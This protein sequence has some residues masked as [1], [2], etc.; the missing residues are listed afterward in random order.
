[1]IPDDASACL[2]HIAVADDS[3]CLVSVVLKATACVAA[4]CDL[5]STASV[6]CALGCCWSLVSQVGEIDSFRH[7]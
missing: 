2:P 4:T 3:A 6:S 5:D 1:M 7:D